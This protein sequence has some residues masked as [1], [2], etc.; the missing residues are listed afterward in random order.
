MALA[1]LYHAFL[2]ATAHLFELEVQV[3]SFPVITGSYR[4]QG[5]VIFSEASVS[6]SVQRGGWSASRGNKRVCIRGGLH[7]GG[8]GFR[9]GLPIRGSAY[10]GCLHRGG[11]SAYGGSAYKEGGLHPSINLPLNS[12]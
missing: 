2:A 3:S 8:S 12:S 10:K 9:E 5:K 1:L 11:G 6:H 4:P 7:P